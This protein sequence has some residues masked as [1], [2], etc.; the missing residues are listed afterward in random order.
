MC[1][2]HGDTKYAFTK[3]GTLRNYQI[4]LSGTNF[5]MSFGE[6]FGAL[7]IFHTVS[8]VMSSFPVIFE[9]TLLLMFT[10]FS[11][12]FHIPINQQFP[13]L[14]WL[15]SIPPATIQRGST[16]KIETLFLGCLE[17][18]SIFLAKT[19]CFIVRWI[20]FF[21]IFRYFSRVAKQCMTI[22]GSY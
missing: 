18:S 5:I 6:H 1:I 12:F 14:L 4:S 15:I 22:G 3:D 7:Q 19:Q 2:R 17:F 9:M 21:C 16:Q 13:E 8:S 11:K 20:I 10:A